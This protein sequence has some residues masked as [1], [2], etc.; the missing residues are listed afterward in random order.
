M[1]IQNVSMHSNNTQNL[2]FTG[3]IIDA[4]AHTGVFADGLNNTCDKFEARHFN[5]ITSQLINGGEDTIEKIIVSNLNCINN[6]SPQSE[7]KLKEKGLSKTFL[8]EIDGNREM[9]QIAKENPVLKPLAVCQPD[10]NA[11][12]DNIRTILKEGEFFGLKFHPLHMQLAADDVKYDDYLKAAEENKLPCLFHCDAAGCKYSSPEQIYTLAKRHPKV[13]VILAH[14]GAGEDSHSRAVNV[15]LESINKGDALIYADISWVDCN[16]VDKKIITDTLKKLQNT[17]K[18]DMTSLL[19]FGTDA[20]IGKF[21]ADGIYDPNY[22]GNNIKQIK[23]SIKNA[24]GNDSE[25]ITNKLFYENAQ[26]LFFSKKAAETVN[27]AK[28]KFG[29][30][31]GI[32]IAAAIVAIGVLANV[33]YKGLKKSPQQKNS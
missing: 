15:L 5:Q 3:K 30:K 1:K 10:K 18:G 13:P 24:F 17:E 22:Y 9:L 27:S 26:E 20:P 33:L 14:L 7:A 16:S 28:K 11:N 21:G 12:A 25:K 19:L 32:F 31:Q 23:T 2:V 8:N 29:A 6:V 4:H